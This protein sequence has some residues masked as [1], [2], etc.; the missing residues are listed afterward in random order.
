MDWEKI[1]SEYAELLARTPPSPPIK[2]VTELPYPREIVWAALMK[3]LSAEKL[4][5]AREALKSCYLGL[6][7]YQ[8]LTLEEKEAVRVVC[9]KPFAALFPGA[10]A[11]EAAHELSKSMPTYEKVALRFSRDTEM[12][13][14]DLREFH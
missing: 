9:C 6:A 2:D 4:A 3:C 7:A 5:S 11:Q 12:L 8:Q 13:A 10:A 1:V 14:T